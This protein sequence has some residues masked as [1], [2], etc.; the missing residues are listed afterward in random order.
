MAMSF[1]VSL[2]VFISICALS[3]GIS[4]LMIVTTIIVIYYELIGKYHVSQQGI[5]Y[6][7]FYEALVFKKKFTGKPVFLYKI[8]TK[9]KVQIGRVLKCILCGIQHA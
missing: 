4:I 5:S 1:D 6:S 9:T 7:G 3:Q 2:K 8:K